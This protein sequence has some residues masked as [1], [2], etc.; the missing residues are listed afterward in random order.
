MAKASVEKVDVEVKVTKTVDEIVLRMSREEAKILKWLIGTK[1]C[2]EYGQ[3]RSNLSNIH[4]ALNITGTH[5]SQ[6][7]YD[8]VGQ[9]YFRE[10]D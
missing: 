10:S 5:A 2:G 3:P 4:A 1:V 6:S 8:A 9:V 7:D